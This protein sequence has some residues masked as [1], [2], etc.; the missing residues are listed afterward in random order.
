MRKQVLIGI[1]SASGTLTLLFGATLILEKNRVS[2][3]ERFFTSGYNFRAVQA[4]DEDFSQYRIGEKIELTKL[5]SIRPDSS[6][7]FEDAKLILLVVVDP[8]CPFVKIS[9]DISKEIKSRLSN[10]GIR[11]LPVVFTSVKP[12]VDLLAYAQSIGFHDLLIRDQASGSLD[13]LSRMPTPSH[14]LVDNEG[15]IL[16]VWFSSSRDFEVSR[17]MS[18]QIISD[19]SLIYE[20][21]I[22]TERARVRH[23]SDL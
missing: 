19:T 4:T 13:I 15:I 11:Y 9:G 10:S 16:Q 12:N 18:A 20:T 17:R 1:V 3:H 8:E 14:V 23:T 2:F 6:Q 22:A 21:Y 7:L 5:R